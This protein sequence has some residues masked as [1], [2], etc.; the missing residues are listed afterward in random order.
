MARQTVMTIVGLVLASVCAAR[1]ARAQTQATTTH[2]AQQTEDQEHSAAALAREATNPFSS[3][4]LMQIQQNNN[5]TEL[6]LDR[7]RRMQSNLM[8]QPLVSLRLTKAWGLYL[9]P[10]VTIFNSLPDVDDDGGRDRTTGF[11]DTVLGAAVARPLFG[12]RLVVGG[13]PT[14]IFPTASQGQLG[15][16]TWQV[17]PDLGVTLLGKSFIA[18]AFVQQWF[19]VGGDGRKTNQ[20]N[21]VFNYTHAF[22]NGWT[23][24][25]QPN[26]SVD[27]E[28][29]GDDGVTFAVGPQVGKMCKCGRTPTLFQ[30]QF[31]YYPI[32]PS[33]AGPRWNVQLQVTPTIS[34]LVKKTLF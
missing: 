22:A 11:G 12:R 25:T 6:P 34:A 18:Y 20:M 9:R 17:G 19:K 15:R 1:S 8:F 31:Q 30:L 10:V 2:G 24:G 14:F 7:G 21:A 3:G 33:A 29:R 5:W 4:W 23:I 32:R 26:L 13:G 16:D 28:A 27:W